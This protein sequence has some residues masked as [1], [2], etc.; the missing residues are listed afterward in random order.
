M[1]EQSPEQALYD[2]LLRALPAKQQRFV[3]EYLIDLNQTQAAIRAGYSE[4]T[5]NE[6]ATRLMKNKRVAA[7]I[8]AGKAI[9]SK[10]TE[11]TQDYVISNLALVVERSLQRAPVLT[12]SGNQV[13]DEEGRHVWKFDAPGANKALELLGKHLGMFSDKVKVEHTGK[14]GGA[15][16]TQTTTT[17]D[18]GSLTD[19]QLRTLASIRIPTS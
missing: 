14:D 11:I 8:E 2:D 1:P 19:E 4:R 15:I 3:E 18:V 17:L 12:M 13:I 9:R 5:A 7:A 16:E 6:Q 10:R